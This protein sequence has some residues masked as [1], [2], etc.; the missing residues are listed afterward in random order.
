MDNLIE[1]VSKITP[2]YDFT[3]YVKWLSTGLMLAAIII[4]ST[5][6]FPIIDFSC[7]SL[8]CLGWA[9]VGYIW[10]DR[11]IMLLN[12]IAGALLIVGLL[13]LLLGVEL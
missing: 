4:R 7:S 11:A 3:W 2:R 10:H 6:L 13:K 9:L 12:G 8:G 1:Q 5:G